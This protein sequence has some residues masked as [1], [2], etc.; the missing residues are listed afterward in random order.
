MEREGLIELKINAKD[1]TKYFLVQNPFPAVGVPEE[2]PRI[3]VDRES[4]KLRF[5]NVISEV[6]STNR[7]ILSVMVGE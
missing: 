4:I 3:T 2:F 5:Q 6:V 7:T 1:Y